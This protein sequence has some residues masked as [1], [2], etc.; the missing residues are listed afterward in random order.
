MSLCLLGLFG[1][2]SKPIKPRVITVTKTEFVPL[3]IPAPLTR[4]T[5][6]PKQTLITNGDLLSINLRLLHALQSCN[7]D[8]ALIKQSTQALKQ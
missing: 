5:P 8:K 6:I 2:T 4:P 3:M 1:C 7:S